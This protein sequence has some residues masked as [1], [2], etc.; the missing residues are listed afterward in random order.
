MS[1]MFKSES[2]T[3]NW[4]KLEFMSLEQFKKLESNT[5]NWKCHACPRLVMRIVYWIQYK[6]LKASGAQ[7][8]V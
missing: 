5:K 7:Y 4:K 1:S 3:K 2:N 8:L 6:E